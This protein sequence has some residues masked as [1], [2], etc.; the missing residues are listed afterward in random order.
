MIPRQI[1]GVVR[2][3]YS[4]WGRR[5]SF[6]YD[7][8]RWRL[9]TGR[10]TFTVVRI[11]VGNKI[12][13]FF[14]IIINKSQGQD[15]STVGAM[16]MSRELSSGA[17]FPERIMRRDL[18]RQVAFRYA[19]RRWSAIFPEILRAKNANVR[20]SST[21]SI[22]RNSRSVVTRSNDTSIEVTSR[23]DHNMP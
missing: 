17:R 16:S 6:I 12:R 13:Y 7:Y 21:Y 11:P 23:H 14:F 9:R 22:E 2:R 8:N 10:G 1:N 18:G 5:C 19:G 4:V 15:L 3:G 20:V